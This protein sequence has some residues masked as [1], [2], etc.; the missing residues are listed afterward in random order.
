M[1]IVKEFEITRIEG[2]TAKTVRDVVITEHCLALYL[3]GRHYVNLLCTPDDLDALVYGYLFTEGIILRKNDIKRLLIH[4]N[5][6]EVSLEAGPEFK[7]AHTVTSGLGPQLT[8]AY[9]SQ[10]TVESRLSDEV[11]LTAEELL[12][13]VNA[14]DAGSSLFASTGGVHS[15]ALYHRDG[16]RIFMEDIGRHNAIDKALGRALLEDWEISQS[17]LLTSGRVPGYMVLKALKTGLSIVISRSAPTDR[18]VEIARQCNMT[19]CGFARGRRVNI[20]SAPQRILT[21]QS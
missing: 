16:R 15:C 2:L 11:F 7:D 13:A 8:T 4:D 21:G 5:R 14:F 1:N 18:A 20:Y 12:D 19:L 10:L 6:A 3:N 17:I 9:S